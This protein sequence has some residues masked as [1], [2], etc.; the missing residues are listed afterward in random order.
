MELRRES[1]QTRSV[2]LAGHTGDVTSYDILPVADG[3]VVVTASWDG[4]VR[5]WDI[6]RSKGWEASG[7]Y[8]APVGERETLGMNRVESAGLVDGVSI[9]IASDA[10]GGFAVWDLRTGRRLRA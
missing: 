5:R 1:G 6:L 7:A 3:H 10:N 2:T 9:G 8:L 4:T